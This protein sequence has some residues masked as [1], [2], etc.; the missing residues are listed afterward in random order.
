MSN[1]FGDFNDISEFIGNKDPSGLNSESYQTAKSEMPSE[2]KIDEY[3]VI[4][5]YLKSNGI[6]INNCADTDQTR[7]KTSPILHVHSTC[8]ANLVKIWHSYPIELILKTTFKWRILLSI[9]K[10]HLMKTMKLETAWQMN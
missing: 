7:C 1:T 8:G 4:L 6:N 3:D 10:K 2:T 9:K 5:H